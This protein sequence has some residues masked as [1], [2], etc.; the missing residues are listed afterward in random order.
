M[1]IFNRIN[2]FPSYKDVSN[3]QDLE[4]DLENPARKDS[5]NNVNNNNVNNDNNN[6][7]EVID[8]INVNRSDNDSES[9]SENENENENDTEVKK[10]PELIDVNNEQTGCII[11]D[12][13][14][15]FDDIYVYGRT[16]I[17][18]NYFN[19]SE[20][21][22]FNLVYPNIYV[23]NYS[24][25]TNFKLLKD[26]GITHIVS[27]IPSFNPP[28]LDKFKYLHIQAYDDESQDIKHYFEISNEFIS[29]CL[30]EGGKVLIHCMVGRSRSVSICMAF[31]IH[32]IQGN[33]HKKSLNLENNDNDNC[34][35]DDIY[36]SVE[37][38]K[39]IKMNNNTKKKTSYNDTNNNYEKINTTEHIKPSLSNKEK[40]YI[41]Y[42]KEVMLNEI[43]DLINIY[44][45]LK[46]EINIKKRCDSDEG[47]DDNAS[48]KTINEL[49][50]IIK[51]MKDQSGQHFIIQLLK[52]IKK[53]RSCAEPN[54]FFIKQLSES[55]F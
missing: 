19:L 12:I 28:F 31:L 22:E 25:S 40:N 8:V 47:I 32:I 15:I 34:S 37:Y 44:T 4:Q 43:D 3:E 55:I 6:N 45:L 17:E 10:T 49:N 11:Y 46:K 2:I 41:V 23:G 7:K 27:V 16:L 51:N 42:K 21:D 29:T 9:E 35:N 38:N 52:Y 14:H 13:L 39:F 54:S 30:N 24:T 1:D 18:N 5:E 36:N 33:F 48:Y 26:L 53:Y 20:N 50:K